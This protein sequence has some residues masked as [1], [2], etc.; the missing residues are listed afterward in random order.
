MVHGTTLAAYMIY[1]GTYRRSIG[2]YM[3]RYDQFLQTQLFHK[4]IILKASGA[5]RLHM[6]LGIYLSL[7]S[8]GPKSHPCRKSPWIFSIYVKPKIDI[9]HHFHIWTPCFKL[10]FRIYAKFRE[11]R[12]KYELLGTKLWWFHDHVR[13]YIHPGWLPARV[14][15]RFSRRTDPKFGKTQES[16]LPDVTWVDVKPYMVM[17]PS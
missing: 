16:P 11:R 1:K 12:T 5:L 15:L 14:T 8:G 7:H 10:G 17:K 9:N 3:D 13:F 6:D 4:T 2:G